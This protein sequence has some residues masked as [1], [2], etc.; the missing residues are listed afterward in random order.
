MEIDLQFGVAREVEVTESAGERRE[1]GCNEPGMEPVMNGDG[2]GA[3]ELSFKM[4]GV[5]G[6]LQAGASVKEVAHLGRWRT[7]EMP[8]R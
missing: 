8:L 2:T 4:L 1:I 5:T 7:T 3:T 6:S